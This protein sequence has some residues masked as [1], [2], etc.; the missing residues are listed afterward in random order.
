MQALGQAAD[1][2]AENAEPVA[3]KVTD[4]AQDVAHKVS[5]LK[6][7]AQALVL[8][9]MCTIFLHHTCS[10]AQLLASCLSQ[11][12]LQGGSPHR[13]ACCVAARHR[14]RVLTAWSAML[15]PRL[16]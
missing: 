4:T 13:P 5:P 1:K 15:H 16:V 12:A 11:A 7:L 9:L 8:H 14:L 10:V 3:Q 6:P 2:V